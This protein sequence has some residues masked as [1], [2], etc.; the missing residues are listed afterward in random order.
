MSGLAFFV[1]MSAL[2]YFDPATG[3]GV[4]LSGGSPLGLHVHEC[5]RM[6]LGASWNYRDVCSPFWRA[7]FNLSEGA[8]VRVGGNRY[9]LGS[10]ALVLLPEEVRF[11]CIASEGVP[12]FWVHFSVTGLWPPPDGPVIIPLSAAEQALWTEL[13]DET[14]VAVAGDI[15]RLRN[16]CAGLLLMAAAQMGAAAVPGGS[17]ELQAWLV[18]LE[19]SLD[20][21]LDIPSMARQAGMGSRAFLNWFKAGT[22]S[23]PMAYLKVRRAREACRRLRFTTES[24]EVIAEGTGFANRYHFSRVFREQT[25][26]TP[27][28]YRLRG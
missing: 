13:S 11:D 8:A 9:E 4:P 6:E 20:E 15:H 14:A 19:R 27:A 1:S 17:P 23:T 25:G 18:W 21:A 10:K 2:T 5:G 16:R 26:R 24:I 22:G 12:H 3:V 28:D 7:Y